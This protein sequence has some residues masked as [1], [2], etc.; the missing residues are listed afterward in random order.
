M[1]PGIDLE[2]LCCGWQEQ[3]DAGNANGAVRAQKAAPVDS[4]IGTIAR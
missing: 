1:I 2:P 4:R 3:T